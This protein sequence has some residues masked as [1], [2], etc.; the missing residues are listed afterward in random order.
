V[1]ATG[2]RGRPDDFLVHHG[3]RGVALCG[4]GPAPVRT[5]AWRRAGARGRQEAERQRMRRVGLYA[6]GV[7]AD[8]VAAFVEGFQLA[9]YR[10]AGYASNGDR[11]PRVQGLTLV[12][13]D[14]SLR[15]NASTQLADVSA[16]VGEVFR[17]RDFVNE[18]ASVATPSFLGD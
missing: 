13:Q 8:G 4:L 5:D 12:G 11:R 6:G 7:A 10:F 15:A 14:S 2:F 9:G 18:P 17:A 3:E 16:V 1:R